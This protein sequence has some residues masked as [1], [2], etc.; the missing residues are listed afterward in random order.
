ML[1]VALGGALR[2]DEFPSDRL[3]GE[4]IGDEFGYLLLPPRKSRG[5][6][7]C[8]GVWPP[9]LVECVRCGFFESRPE[10]V[11][12]LRIERAV[13]HRPAGALLELGVEN[14]H[15]WVVDARTPRGTG[16]RRDRTHQPG[17][18]PGSSPIHRDPREPPYT[19]LR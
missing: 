10:A 8:G 13:T 14:P 7:L 16:E 9:Y 2:N 19:P 11:T 6:G 3:V 4:A 15:I 12:E 1:H 17:G 5:S 18:A